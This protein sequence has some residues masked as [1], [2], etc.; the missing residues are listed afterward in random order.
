MDKAGEDRLAEPGDG[1]LH[2]VALG[3]LA[4]LIVNDHALKSAYPGVVTGKL[5]DVAGLVFFPL[6][7]VA[8]LELI[9]AIRRRWR[10]PS[11]AASEIAVV[12]T[13][14]AFAAVKLLPV[15]AHAFGWSLGLAQWLASVPVDLVTGRGVSPLAAAASVADPT[16][17]LALPA[18]L[19]PLW[20]GRRRA[21]QVD[22]NAQV[23]GVRQAVETG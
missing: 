10:G 16:D 21:A 18:L 19:V 20:L 22:R 15:G 5:S 3:S 14:L 2:P 9:Q 4:M 17:L 7:L 12:A 11:G 23:P 8:G 6:L 1:L 13:G